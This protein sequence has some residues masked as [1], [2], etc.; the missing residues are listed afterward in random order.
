MS[1]ARVQEARLADAQ[2]PKRGRGCAGLRS[3]AGSKLRTAVQALG[4]ARTLWMHPFVQGTA[5]PH[6]SRQ[7]AAAA[8]LQAACAPFSTRQAARKGA[9]PSL[10]GLSAERDEPP[11]RW[12]GRGPRRLALP[13]LLPG[14]LSE[15]TARR[16]SGS[17][18]TAA[19][20]P[21]LPMPPAKLA[22]AFQG[23]R[24]AAVRAPCSG[25]CPGFVPV[26]RP[27]ALCTPSAL[28]TFWMVC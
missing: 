2:R 21:P 23:A 26:P 24:G 17:P 10:P 20:W 18:P 15:D 16:A 25:L 6:E 7:L 1:E 3:A 19:A 5:V 14:A 12:R 8:C 22:Q 4:M 28:P 13:R 11:P 27:P 9:R